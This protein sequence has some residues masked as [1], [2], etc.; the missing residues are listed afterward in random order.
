MV[1]VQLLHNTA[2]ISANLTACFTSN[3]F[4]L[5]SLQHLANYYSI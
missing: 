4:K 1:F 5:T 2:K 3:S